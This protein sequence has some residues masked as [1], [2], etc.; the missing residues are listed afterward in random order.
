MAKEKIAGNEAG[1]PSTQGGSKS[2]PKSKTEIRSEASTHC[3][4]RGVTE[5]RGFCTCHS[6]GDP[7]VLAQLGT[8]LLRA[9]IISAVEGGKWRALGLKLKPRGGAARGCQ[10]ENQSGGAQALMLLATQ[11]GP[12]SSGGPSAAPTVCHTCCENDTPRRMAP[13]LPPGR[14]IRHHTEQE[15]AVGADQ[16][17]GS[18]D[19]GGPPGP[20]EQQSLR[21]WAEE[22]GQQK[23]PSPPVK[24]STHRGPERQGLT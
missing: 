21:G 8:Q 17:E 3:P 2:E 18:W 12:H 9:I 7:P 13:A 22:W 11:S 1:G 14:A 5:T 23:G 4:G 24:K 6:L 20:Q 10:A 15:Q 19:W 16:L